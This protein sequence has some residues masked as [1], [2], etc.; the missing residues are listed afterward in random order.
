MRTNP[1]R[2][3]SLGARDVIRKS[4]ISYYAGTEGG[5]AWEGF[6]IKVKSRA[7]TCREVH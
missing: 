6:I 3:S 1:E 7:D 5:G 4:R 2:F